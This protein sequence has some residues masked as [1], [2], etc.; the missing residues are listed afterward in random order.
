ME[1]KLERITHFV[2]AFDKRNPDPHKNYG[3]GS[4][5]CMMVL[6]GKNGAVHFIFSTGMFLPETIKEY[7]RDKR[8]LFH[9]NYEGGEV[10]QSYYMGFDVG[11]HSHKPEFDGQHVSQTK[12][13]WLDGKP[14]YSDGSGLRAEEWMDIFIRKGSDEI[15]KMLE[16]DYKSR[17]K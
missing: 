4:V 7:Y 14:C 2:P 1:E 16:E 6:K 12:C 3:I 15:W 13:K 17:F 11:Y 5:K 10:K 8:D 9:F